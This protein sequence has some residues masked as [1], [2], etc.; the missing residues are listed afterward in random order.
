[1][2]LI[3][4]MFLLGDSSGLETVDS[5]FVK[6]FLLSVMALL[7]SAVA[8]KMLFGGRTKVSAELD[9]EFV[10]RR[11]FDKLETDIEQSRKEILGEV[12]KLGD[13]LSNLI[14][15]IGRAGYEGRKGLHNDVTKISATIARLDERVKNVEKGVKD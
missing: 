11:E 13:R 2:T 3:A 1:M 6:N 12:E 14:E 9:E 10:T 4:L 7:A 8:V 15:K 5:G